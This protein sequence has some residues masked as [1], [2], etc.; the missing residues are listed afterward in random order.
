MQTFFVTFA[1]MEKAMQE[2]E[3]AFRQAMT[4]ATVPMDEILS[5]VALTSGKRLRPKLVFLSAELFGEINENTQ[6]AALF[7]EMLHTATLIHDDIVDGSETR[8]GHASVHVRWD[9]SSALLTG[10]YIL[11]KAMQQLT[12]QETLPVLN[13]VMNTVMAMSEGELIQNRRQ[14]AED[15]RQK[16]EEEYL[17]LITRKT[18]L[19]F[20]SS[21][22]SGALSVGA[23]PENASLVKDFGLYY[24]IVFQMRDDLLDADDEA[25]I[26]YA[27]MLM[28]AYLEKAMNYLEALEP[29]VLNKNALSTLRE[30]TLFSAH[31]LS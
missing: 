11:A 21:C 1:A 14:K 10:D 28:P 7:V 31:R 30:L 17:D 3:D 8:R 15:R 5:K 26:R 13:E 2:F 16:T 23:A 25:S 29:K 22:Y 27:E 9:T 4:S 19:L 6:R 24:G 20:S 12:N 18:A